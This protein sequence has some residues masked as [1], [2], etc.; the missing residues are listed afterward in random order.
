MWRPITAWPWWTRRWVEPVAVAASAAMMVSL[1]ACVTDQT[2]AGQAARGRELFL[3]NCA[4]C[5]APDATGDEG[6]DLHGVAKSD[7]KIAL[8]IKNGIQGKMPRFR[9]KFSEAD[10]AA[11]MSFIDSLK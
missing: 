2:G 5:H 9:A 4:H 1:P 11:L 3:M 6:P 8:L 10:V 7:N